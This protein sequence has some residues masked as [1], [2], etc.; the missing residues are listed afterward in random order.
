MLLPP[1]LAPETVPEVAPGIASGVASEIDAADVFALAYV[2]AS[3]PV[4]V[5]ELAPTAA[6]NTVTS[7]LLYICTP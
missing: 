7:L 4:A 2:S 5:L 1:V 6:T 3:V